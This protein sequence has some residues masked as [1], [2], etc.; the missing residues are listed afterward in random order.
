[1]ATGSGMG[2]ANSA[3]RKLE[4]GM[5]V[6][7]MLGKH[8]CLSIIEVWEGVEIGKWLRGT[9]DCVGDST[10][11]GVIVKDKWLPI[12]LTKGDIIIRSTSYEDN[13]KT[14]AVKRRLETA[15]RKQRR[16][17]LESLRVIRSEV[18]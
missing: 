12:D 11:F 10:Q 16:G 14:T 17:I 15:A 7:V 3:P 4:V 1:M 6:V 5:K 18:S 8:Q 2:H 13:L 9:I